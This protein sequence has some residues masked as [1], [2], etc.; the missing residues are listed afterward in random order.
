M[1][2][3]EDKRISDDIIEEYFCCD[4]CKCKGECCVEGDAGAPLE[5]EEIDQIEENIDSI[6]KYM[7]P[8]GIKSIGKEGVF[9]VDTDGDYTTPLVNGQEC[10]YSFQED[11]ITLCAIERAYRN[12]DIP[13][14]KPISCHL[15]PIRTFKM[16][17][18]HTGLNYHIWDI[19]KE[20]RINGAEKQIK[21]YQCVKEPIIRAFGKEFYSCLEQADHL[22]TTEESEKTE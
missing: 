8:E 13:F 17:N 6:K 3:I 20:A 14:N 15:Y 11:S 4:L 21:V 19:C 16:R 1:L 2:E 18:G 22:Y 10:A 5:E 12:G 9:V 7:T